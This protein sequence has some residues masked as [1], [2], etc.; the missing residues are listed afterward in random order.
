MCYYWTGACR[1][2]S[3]IVEHLNAVAKYGYGYTRQ[4]VVELASDYAVQLGKR[5]PDQPLTIKWIRTFIG[6]WPELRVLKPRSLEQ[7]RATNTV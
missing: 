1:E 4:E 7:L 5:K 3:H 2:E 6:C